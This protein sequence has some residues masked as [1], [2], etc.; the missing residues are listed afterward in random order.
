MI[1]V[2]RKSI[3]LVSSSSPV[4][5]FSSLKCSLYSLPALEE[6]GAKIHTDTTL[7]LPLPTLLLSTLMSTHQVLFIHAVN[8]GSN[9]REV[10]HALR[11]RSVGNVEGDFN[12]VSDGTQLGL[13]GTGKG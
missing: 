12:V 11:R 3:P 13:E 4:I 5:S 9:D 7:L 8:V 6:T 10:L 1:D 2:P